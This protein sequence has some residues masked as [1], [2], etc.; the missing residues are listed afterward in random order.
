MVTDFKKGEVL[1]NINCYSPSGDEFQL[2]CDN[3]DFY[4]S[5]DPVESTKIVVAKRNGDTSVEE[6]VATMNIV[7]DFVPRNFVEENGVVF[8]R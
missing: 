4:V 1:S 3:K 7:I 5:Q 6:V 8:I 2:I